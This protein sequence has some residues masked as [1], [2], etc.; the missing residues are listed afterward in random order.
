MGLGQAWKRFVPL[1]GEVGEKG[2]DLG[3]GHLVGVS[4]AVEPDEGLG[5][6]NIDGGLGRR[7]AA[8]VEGGSEPVEE[9]RLA[10]SGRGRERG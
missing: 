7:D 5:P 4:E 1:D 9:P 3:L 2:P 10:G 6:A 8:E